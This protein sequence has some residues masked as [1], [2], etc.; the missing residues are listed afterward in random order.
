MRSLRVKAAAVGFAIFLIIAGLAGFVPAFTPHGLLFG[1][2]RVGRVHSIIHLVAGMVALLCAFVGVD[3]SR[4]YFQIF[5]LAF[6]LVGLMGFFYGNH[7]LL[8]MVQH[9]RADIGLEVAIA[10]VALFFGF[11]IDPL[12]SA[13]TDALYF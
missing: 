13:D 2:F 3:A 12:P 5:G 7:P 10:A 11:G 6:T 8:G 4:K 1:I 9:N